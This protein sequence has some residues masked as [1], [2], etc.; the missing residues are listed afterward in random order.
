LQITDTTANYAA[1]KHN[2]TDF[3]FQEYTAE[4]ANLAYIAKMSGV[5]KTTVK[6]RVKTSGL[7]RQD[8]GPR[9]QGQVPYGWRLLKGRLVKHLR[10]QKIIAEMAV[11]RAD[12]ASFGDL[13][14]W[15][16]GNGVKT[17][18]GAGNWDRP[19]VYKILKRSLE[20]PHN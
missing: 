8:N 18:N 3:L 4:G 20:P 7:K 1:Q 14:D 13:V 11:R 19:T 9:L 6:K 2:D 10:E 16:N 12:G 15:L 5:S 17:K